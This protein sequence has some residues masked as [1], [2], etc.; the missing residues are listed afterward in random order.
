MSV[1]SSE[2][3]DAMVDDEFDCDEED[4]D[5]IHQL[6]DCPNPQEDETAMS[7]TNEERGW[8]LELRQ[9]V[10]DDDDR[11]KLSDFEYTQYAIVTQGHL[12]DALK[13][14]A[15]VQ[16]F[17]QTHNV[18]RSQSEMV[19]QGVDAI[20]AFLKQQPGMLLSIDVD[21][22]T[23]EGIQ[24]FD[25]G[26]VNP[27]AALD[28]SS[29]NGVEYH[30]KN[31]LPGFYYMS[32]ASNP[33]L[34]TVR[35]GGFHMCDFQSYGW[36]SWSMQLQSRFSDEFFKDNPVRYRK[37]LCFNTGSVATV[38]CSLLKHIYP[39]AFV[40]ALQ[41]GCKVPLEENDSVPKSLADKY[42]Q[43]SMEEAYSRL[44]LRVRELLTLRAKNEQLFCL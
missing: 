22:V 20:G 14:M 5:I 37:V 4:D 24:V 2:N 38:C 10:E 23:F 31:W 42:L 35:R 36:M 41:L 17:R 28:A 21:P 27:G 39:P 3:H 33:L 29:P 8:A 16:R 11:Q 44:L 18:K 9:A 30:L 25:I 15:T 6:L 26:A 43:P 40:S 19:Q 1:T 34:A 13:H 7:I 12:Q 32:V